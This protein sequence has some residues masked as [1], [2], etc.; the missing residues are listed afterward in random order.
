MAASVARNGG[1]SL[2]RRLRAAARTPP[3]RSPTSLVTAARCAPSPCRAI[4]ARP[5]RI[6]QRG[7]YHHAVGVSRDRARLLG[8]AHA[9]ADRD[10]QLRVALDARDRRRTSLASGAA[11]PVMPV[12]ET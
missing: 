6:D 3:A 12:I 11:A 5:H 8:R 9:E 1:E 4:E 7:A 10:R 2:F